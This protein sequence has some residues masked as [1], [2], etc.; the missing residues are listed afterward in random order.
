MEANYIKCTKKPRTFYEA[1]KGVQKNYT[2]IQC[3]D[4]P[5]YP[6]AE[7]ISLSVSLTGKFDDVY[8]SRPFRY[9]TPARVDALYPR[10]GPKDGDTVVQVWG[11]NFLDLG[12][13]FR[14]NWGTKSTKAHFVSDSFIW[15]RS[16]Q[17]AVVGKAMP[18]SVSLN[19]QQNTL[20]R[21]DFWYYNDPV[22]Q[23]LE[24]DFGPV[25]GGANIT[26]KGSGFMPFDWASDIDNRNDTF[27][28]WDELGKVRA[29]VISYTLAQCLVP[30]NTAGLTTL[31]LK[32]TLNNQ[33][34][35]EGTM[36]TYYNPPQIV[37]AGPLRG[38]VRGGTEVHVYGPNYDKGRDVICIFGSIKTKAQVVTKTHIKCTAPPFPTARDVALIVQYE[39]DR[40]KSSQLTFT[41]YDAAYI[42][43]IAPACGPVQGY[44]QIRV[45]GTGFVANNGFG[46]ARCLFN[47]TYYTNATVIDPTTMYCDSPPLDLGE[48]ESGDYLYNLSVSADG[49]AYS[50]ASAIF[51]YYDQPE[52]DSVSPWLGPMDGETKVNITGGGFKNANMCNP[53]VKFG[54]H[55]YTPAISSDSSLQVDVGES[56]LPGSVVVTMSGNG[57]QYTPDRTLHYRDLQNTFEYY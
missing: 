42:D 46:K 28:V 23:K 7:I 27:C 8:S 45:K 51:S 49:E 3:E 52:I 35:T 56:K 17:S 15:C 21:L 43:S 11:A 20:Q 50:N 16:A 37:D 13:D 33:N 36:F 44:T 54:Q 14:C 4:S 19:R 29:E 24:P 38:P 40:F 41:Y 25:A 12:D 18:F 53:K 39:N 1:E 47:R 2:C 31:H 5:R 34:I 30:P 9:Y 57:Q 48:S 6:Q 32:L 10:Y 26:I 55:P 22:I